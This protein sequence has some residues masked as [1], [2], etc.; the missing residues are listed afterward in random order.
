[1]AFRLKWDRVLPHISPLAGRTIL[2]VG[3]GSGYHLWRMIGAGAHFAVGIDPMQLFLCQFEAVRKL[4]GGDQRAHLLP[5]GIEQL[6]DLAAFDTV[7]SMGY[8][9]TAARRSI[10]SIS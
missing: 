5:L 6:P 3:C 8:C 7:F 4:L 10:I 2:D 9:I 1:M